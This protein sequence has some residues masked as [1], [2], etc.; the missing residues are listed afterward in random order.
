M[1][2]HSA[3]EVSGEIVD[4][5]QNVTFHDLNQG[6]SAGIE[7]PTTVLTEAPMTTDVFARFHV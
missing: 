1:L 5:E 3:E 4:V 6:E 7:A 2:P